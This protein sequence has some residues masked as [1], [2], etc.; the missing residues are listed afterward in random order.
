MSLFKLREWWSAKLGCEEYFSE[1]GLVVGNLDNSQENTPKIITGSLQGRIRVHDP[2]ICRSKADDATTLLLETR[3]DA[4]I[5]QLKLGRLI[6]HDTFSVAL[7]ILHPNK[8]AV[9]TCR[10]RSSSLKNGS[11]EGGETSHFELVP[12]YTHRFCVHGVQFNAYSMCL[13]P[14]GGVLDRDLTLVQSMDG[15]VTIYEHDV[16]FSAL[17]I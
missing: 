5:L 8:L 12:L 7:A 10:A 13:G 14:F 1:G 15:R 6:P 17:F 16:G 9:Y 3:L 4:P 11:T 2:Q